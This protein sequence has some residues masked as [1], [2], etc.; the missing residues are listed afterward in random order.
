MILLAQYGSKK[1]GDIVEVYPGAFRTL[2]E[3]GKAIPLEQYKEDIENGEL[4]SY[5]KMVIHSKIVMDDNERLFKENETL[6]DKNERL[7]EEVERLKEKLKTDQKAAKKAY[8]EKNKMMENYSKKNGK[9]SK[10]SRKAT[11]YGN[12]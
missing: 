10:N 7:G 3:L 6:T 2:L 1:A 8:Y 9:Q 4:D 5:E 11:N 12:E